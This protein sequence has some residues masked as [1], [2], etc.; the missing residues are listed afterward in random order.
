MTPAIHL[1]QFLLLSH[2]V[3]LSAMQFNHLSKPG[4]TCTRARDGRRL[5]T[6]RLS[7]IDLVY[8]LVRVITPHQVGHLVLAQNT[9]VEAVATVNVVFAKLE[10]TR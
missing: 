3:I 4:S 7:R 10:G 6:G 1:L 2:A 9:G 8:L 5:G